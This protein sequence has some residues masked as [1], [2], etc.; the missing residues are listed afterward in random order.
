LQSQLLKGLL[1]SDAEDPSSLKESS[2]LP[3]S[4]LLK[5]C[6][7]IYLSMHDDELDDVHGQREDG[8]KEVPPAFL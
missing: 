4:E 5:F 8:P 7:G 2:W 3:M 1:R 6:K